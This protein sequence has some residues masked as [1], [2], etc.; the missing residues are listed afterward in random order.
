MIYTNGKDYRLRELTEEDERGLYDLL[1][2]ESGGLNHFEFS[3]SYIGAFKSYSDFYVLIDRSEDK[4]IGYI[5]ITAHNSDTPE[6]GIYL[7]EEYR[8]QGIATEFIPK[9]A[10]HYAE[11]NKIRYITLTLP[12][13]NH[14]LTMNLISLNCSG[15]SL[16]KAI[17]LCDTSFK[18]NWGFY[19]KYKKIFVFY[20]DNLPKKD[21]RL[22]GMSGTISSYLHGIKPGEFMS[23]EQKNT[24]NSPSAVIDSL[25]LNNY[26]N[27]RVYYSLKNDEIRRLRLIQNVPI[28]YIFEKYHMMIIERFRQHYP[29]VEFVRIS[30]HNML[31]YYI[32]K[33]FYIDGHSKIY[34]LQADGKIATFDI[35]DW[36]RERKK[37][38]S[39]RIKRSICL[40]PNIY[41]FL[42]TINLYS[43]CLEEKFEL[44]YR[45]M[46]RFRR[47]S[48]D[49]AINELM[50]DNN[51]VIEPRNTIFSYTLD[52]ISNSFTAE[53]RSNI[54]IIIRFN[55]LINNLIS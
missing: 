28:D 19:K 29:T 54:G 2:E 38:M 40:S 44:G 37:A 53:Q 49:L 47:P 27:E 36:G 15:E 10:T 31:D 9:A 21:K 4:Y 7:R 45:P 25:H 8:N 1:C 41:T 33:L 17:V 32:E 39:E 30:Y 18:S 51:M 55:C 20:C 50:K 48:Y 35:G 11:K 6:I 3:R 42:M 34:G 13:I 46:T 14:N 26:I 23:Q 12:G 5:N 22:I 24:L 52:K 16:E 43:S